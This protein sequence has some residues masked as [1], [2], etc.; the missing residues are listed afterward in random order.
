MGLAHLVNFPTDEERAQGVAGVGPPEPATVPQTRRVPPVPG[1]EPRGA[2]RGRGEG[3]GAEAGGESDEE[4]EDGGGSA[5]SDDE[6][7]ADTRAEASK[8]RGVGAN[9]AIG[10]DAQLL[11]Q[12]SEIA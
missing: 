5:G 4:D 11:S 7:E 2:K 12:P 10:A 3:A 6:E 8:Y 1:A 9:G